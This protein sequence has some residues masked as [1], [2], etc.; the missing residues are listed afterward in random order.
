[1]TWSSRWRDKA[2]PMTSK[3]GPMLAEEQGVRMTNEFI[4]KDRSLTLATRLIGGVVD[5]ESVPRTSDSNAAARLGAPKNS[6]VRSTDVGRTGGHRLT[7][8][9]D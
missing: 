1:M 5:V 9:L 7:G 2:R 3:P 6:Y 4:V 8:V